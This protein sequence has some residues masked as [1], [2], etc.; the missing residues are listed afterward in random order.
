MFQNLF[1]DFLGLFFPVRC[2]SCEKILNRNENF[3][4]NDCLSELPLTHFNDFENNLVTKTFW[5]RVPF[6][7]GFSLMHF[8]KR[9]ITQTI[10]HAIKYKG[11]AELAV[12][13][14]EMTGN[15][16]IELSFPTDTIDGFLPVPLHPRKEKLRGFNQ[17]AAFAQGLSKILKKPVLKNTVQRIKFTATQTKLSK[18]QRWQNVRNIFKITNPGKLYGKH[19]VIVDDVLTTGATIEAL[20]TEILKAVGKINLSFLTLA[21]AKII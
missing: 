19:I 6:K 18:E 2:I 12:F 7:Y 10:L 16:L 14:G 17:A 9:S 15:R 11:K 21:T 1:N 20:A 3:I 8:V 13:F 5:D 4:C